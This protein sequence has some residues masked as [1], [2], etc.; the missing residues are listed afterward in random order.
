MAGEAAGEHR[1]LS[2]LPQ[3]A[4]VAALLAGGPA[5]AQQPP[6]PARLA[7]VD[8]PDNVRE[9]VAVTLTAWNVEILDVSA[10][11]LGPTMP[12]TADAAR[13]VAERHQVSAVV[14]ISSSDGGAALWVLDGA[15]DKV[16]ARPLSSA[17]PFD[18]AT[19]AAIALTIKTLLRHSMVAPQVERFGAAEI[20]APPPPPPEPELRIGIEAISGIRVRPSGTAGVE[21]RLGL[22]LF[23]APGALAR[24]LDV[25]LAVRVGLGS[26]VES[27]A[28]A[29]TF[30]DNTLSAQVRL[31]ALTAPIAIAPTAGVSLHMTR[32]DGALSATSTTVSVD[33]I[34]P[35]IDA[36]VR[37]ALGLGPLDLGLQIEGS[38][39]LRRQRY[40]VAGDPVLA[41]PRVEL[42]I[43]VV[44]SLP[45]AE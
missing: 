33:R 16:V 23:W 12:A 17:P 9:A 24:R 13:V 15:T 25:G 3:A 27:P 32:L 26:S 30:R 21:P 1:S 7:L 40:E 2:V 31:R 6:E 11:S 39:A 8:L 28:L 20:A 38:A 42:E 19:A 36:G 35:S 29:A 44:V 14:W 4:I 43:G 41:L 45:T 37:A 10:G 22:G 5:Y 18:D 34:N